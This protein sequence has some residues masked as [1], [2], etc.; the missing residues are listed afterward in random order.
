M[1]R[2]KVTFDLKICRLEGSH[3]NRENK[4]E[5]A[6]QLY[7]DQGIYR[8]SIENRLYIIFNESKSSSVEFFEENQTVMIHDI[9][10]MLIQPENYWFKITVENK[11]ILVCIILIQRNRYASIGDTHVHPLGQGLREL[12]K[13][14]FEDGFLSTLN[15]VSSNLIQPH[16][17]RY[18][19]GLD[20]FI[21]LPKNLV[22]HLES[23]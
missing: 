11:P 6:K 23:D 5:L 8:H 3:W 21:L 4:T 19:H 12:S 16:T 17:N 13:A 20:G 14:D 2:I 9:I 22:T 7:K 1:E 18:E 15:W 10:Q